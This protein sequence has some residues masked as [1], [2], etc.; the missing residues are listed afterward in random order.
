MS[1]RLKFRAF[2]EG[3]MHYRKLDDI[4]VYWS[5]NYLEPEG[6]TIIMQ[7]TGIK[8]KNGKLIYESD[9]VRCGHPSHHDGVLEG[10]IEWDVDR[11]VAN[12]KGRAMNI[13]LR[14]KDLEVIGNIY[15]KDAS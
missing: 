15:E 6:A 3:E 7:S 14:S 4:G 5:G 8:D 11:F 2:H 10:V 1:D 9:K 13:S 12:R